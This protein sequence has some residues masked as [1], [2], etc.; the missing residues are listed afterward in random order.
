M[1]LPRLA[2]LEDVNRLTGLLARGER[3]D[4]AEARRI[5]GALR[6]ALAPQPRATGREDEA[7]E[8]LVLSL[9]LTPEAVV[10]DC[11]LRCPVQA[12]VCLARQYQSD[13]EMQ[14]RAAPDRPPELR[15]HDKKRGTTTTRPTCVTSRCAVG[16]RV[17]LLLGD[18]PEARAMAAR[19]PRSGDTVEG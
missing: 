11:P 8:Q 7:R 4:V 1:A 15:R 9:A 2:L 17:R 14:R 19:A 12:I 16:A 18:R 6:R 10:L 5:T 13:M 3:G